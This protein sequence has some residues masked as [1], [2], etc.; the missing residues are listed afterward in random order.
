MKKSVF[1]VS[2]AFCL[3]VS[4]RSSGQSIIMLADNIKGASLA[5]P[6]AIDVSSMGTNV[7]CTACMVTPSQSGTL[8]GRASGGKIVFNMN[9]E[10]AVNNFKSALL[11]GSSNGSAYFIFSK[12]SS[13]GK[14][15]Y[16]Y[17]KLSNFTVIEIDEATQAG[18]NT[19]VQVSL[20]YSALIWTVKPQNS[21]GELGNP[22]SFGWDFGKNIEV[23]GTAIPS[24]Y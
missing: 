2:L 4:T 11:K 18:D 24:G 8:A 16:Y 21:R 10:V 12:P 14:S 7:A 22:V 20:G 6:G 5:S 15:N 9:S 3:A 13:T 19:N 1:L 23:S 17:I